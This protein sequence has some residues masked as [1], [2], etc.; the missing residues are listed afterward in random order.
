MWRCCCWR[1]GRAGRRGPSRPGRACGGRY[2][3]PRLV[4]PHHSPAGSRLHRLSRP[5][6]RLRSGGST[7][8]HRSLPPLEEGQ[9]SFVIEHD[10]VVQAVAVQIDDHRRGPPLGGQRVPAGFHQFHAGLGGVPSHSTSI[11]WAAASCGVPRADVAIPT[12]LPQI[13]LATRSGRSSWSQSAT[14]GWC[15]P[16][17]PRTGLGSSRWSRPGSEATL[18]RLAAASAPPTGRPQPAP[19]RFS[20]NPMSRRVATNQVLVAVVVPVETDRRHQRAEL[21]FVGLL[22]EE[23]RRREQ[24]KP[25]A[26]LPV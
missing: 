21:D 1:A 7:P 8:A 2:V 22:L 14:S 24:G 18:R 5:G 10:Q 6:G 15:S 25:S 3:R 23:A 16:T 20:M 12:T 26:N 17:W 11:G 9:V 13:E 19:A 4:Q